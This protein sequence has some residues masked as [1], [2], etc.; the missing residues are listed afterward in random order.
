MRIDYCEYSTYCGD[1]G[2][3]G[4][5]KELWYCPRRHYCKYES[6]ELPPTKPKKVEAPIEITVNTEIKHSKKTAEHYD[7]L[8]PTIKALITQGMT[9]W[10][11]IGKAVKIKPNT[12]QWYYN[13]H[14]IKFDGMKIKAK[15]I[16]WE[17]I[18]PIA[19]ER[20]EQ[21]KP[22]AEIANEVGIN[23]ETLRC[24]MQ[25]EYDVY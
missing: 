25:R 20:R 19:R 22:W 8:I 9:T 15:D 16:D 24:R 14:G 2:G 12:L 17:K 7:R 23:R 18:V 1:K 3:E 21:N 5:S 10:T 11:E 4:K 13:R 6:C